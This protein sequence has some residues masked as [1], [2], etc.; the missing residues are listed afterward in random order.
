MLLSLFIAISL[1]SDALAARVYNGAAKSRTVRLMTFGA[2]KLIFFTKRYPAKGCFNGIRAE[3]EDV[4]EGHEQ[5]LRDIVPWLMPQLIHPEMKTVR[6]FT[7]NAMSTE[8][9]CGWKREGSNTPD[10]PMHYSDVYEPRAIA[11]GGEL[12]V[13]AEVGLHISYNITPSL[14]YISEKGWGL[15]ATA[16]QGGDEV[17]HLLQHPDTLECQLTFEGTDNVEEWLNNIDMV[18]KTFCNTKKIHRGFVEVLFRQC[19]SPEFQSKIRPNLG[20]CSSITVVG[21]S[22]GGAVGSLWAGCV[23]GQNEGNADYDKLK[24]KWYDPKKLPTL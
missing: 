6:L 22:L 11:F 14:S 12:K 1:C 3:T 19:D 9:P 2:P 4:Q 20:Y 7:D 13:A 17:S 21:H 24:F 5:N 16:V 23:T 10:I 8:H 15:V 18:T